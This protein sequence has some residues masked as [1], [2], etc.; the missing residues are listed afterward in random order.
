MCAYAGLRGTASW[1]LDLRCP[2]CNC[3]ILHLSSIGNCP[4]CGYAIAAYYI[5]LRC[6][7]WVPTPADPAEFRHTVMDPDVLSVYS[8]EWF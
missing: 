3:G 2:K 7:E 5:G 4:V 1:A 8:L 6:G